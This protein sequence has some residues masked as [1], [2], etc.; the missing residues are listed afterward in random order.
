MQK[1]KVNKTSASF[2]LRLGDSLFKEVEAIREREEKIQGISVSLN[3]T[4]I[5][6]VRIGIAELKKSENEKKSVMQV[7]DSTMFSLFS[8]KRGFHRHERDMDPV[9]A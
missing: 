5:R 3:S 1:Q 6:L 7:T 4:I 8:N 2:P 9:A